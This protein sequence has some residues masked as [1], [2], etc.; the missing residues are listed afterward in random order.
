[1]PRTDSRREQET[2]GALHDWDVHDIFETKVIRAIRDGEQTVPGLRKVGG[3]TSLTDKEIAAAAKDILAEF[4]TAEATLRRM[5]PADSADTAD[6]PEWEEFR[7]THPFLPETAWDDVWDIAYEAIVRPPRATSHPVHGGLG[8]LS[9]AVPYFHIP[10]PP[11]YVAL[12]IQR[13]DALRADIARAKQQV[14]DLKAELARLQ[15]ARDKIVRPKGL[16]G[17]LV[18]LGFF[19]LVGVVIPIWL[20]SRGPTRLTAHLGEVIFWLFFVGLLALLGYMAVL[21]LRLSGWRRSSGTDRHR[22]GRIPWLGH[23]RKKLRGQSSWPVP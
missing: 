12:D 13:R 7:H 15:N 2:R 14:E 4:D 8:A 21:A 10:T 18:V 9:T 6:A 17:G 11:E 3:Y 23:W 1:M 5:I 19:T 20:M 22:R 16:M